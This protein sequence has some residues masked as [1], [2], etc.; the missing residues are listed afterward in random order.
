MGTKNTVP[1][2]ANSW[3]MDPE[4]SRDTGTDFTANNEASHRRNTKRNPEQTRA[5]QT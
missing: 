5:L 1:R 4:P 3:T 2:I